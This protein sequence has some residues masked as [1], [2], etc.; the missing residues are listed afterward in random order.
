MK[1]TRFR[2]LLEKVHRIAKQQG[3]IH[4]TMLAAILGISPSYANHL[5]KA[6]GEFFPDIEYRSGYII[7]LELG[8]KGSEVAGVVGP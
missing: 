7:H 8:E 2:W 6:A 1:Q 5:A 4:Y 3:R